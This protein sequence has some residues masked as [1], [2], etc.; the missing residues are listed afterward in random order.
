[1][2]SVAKTVKNEAS[3][4]VFFYKCIAG[5]TYIVH[6]VRQSSGVGGKEKDGGFTGELRGKEDELQRQFR[7]VCVEVFH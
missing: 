3:W 5:T 7:Q 2:T 6:R 4:A 1:M